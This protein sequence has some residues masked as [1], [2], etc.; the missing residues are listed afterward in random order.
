MRM[1]NF[2][3]GCNSYALPSPCVIEDKQSGRTLQFMALKDNAAKFRH[4]H[5]LTQRRKKQLANAGGFRRPIA[6]RTKKFQRGYHAQWRDREEQVGPPQSGTLVQGEGQLIDIKTVQVSKRGSD[7][8]QER[9][10]QPPLNEE[11]AIIMDDMLARVSHFLG[12]TDGASLNALSTFLIAEIGRERYD[13][14]L[15]GAVG[16]SVRGALAAAL[17]MFP[18]FFTLSA[19]NLRVSLTEDARVPPRT[20]P[21]PGT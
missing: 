6:A 8:P 21:R 17:Q 5:G 9:F 16:R 4:N 18:E 19:N 20:R 2:T 12:E 15:E 11:R 3:L 13:A 14:A 1:P 10:A 7:D